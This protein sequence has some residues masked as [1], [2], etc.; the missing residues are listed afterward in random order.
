MVTKKESIKFPSLFLL[1]FSALVVGIL[2]SGYSYYIDSEKKI[3]AEEKHSLSLI[4]QFRANELVE[5]RNERFSDALIIYK[6][7]SMFDLIQKSFRNQMDSVLYHQTY[8]WLEIMHK[9]NFYDRITIIDKNDRQLLTVPENTTGSTSF[10]KNEIPGAMV[11]DSITWI[12]FYRNTFDKKIYI[13]LCI[14]IKESSR[15]NNPIGFVVMRIDPEKYL[16]AL[17]KNAVDLEPN[18]K[19]L[20]LR[21][22]GDSIVYLHD[23][24]HKKNAALN[25]R[26]SMQQTNVLGV[27]AVR[28]KEGIAEGVDYTGASVLGYIQ[29]IPN[30]PWY[31]VAK[32]D[33][34]IIDQK[35]NEQIWIVVVFCTALTFALGGVIGLVWRQQ[36]ITY[37]KEK[38]KSISELEFLQTVIRESLNEIYIFKERTLQFTFVNE[39]ASKNLGYGIGE[40]MQMKAFAIKP[41]FDEVKY[42]SMI[43]PLVNGEKE[44]IV[45]ETVHRRSD[46][47]TYPVETHLQLIIIDQEKVILAVVNDITL[48]KQAEERLNET[49]EYLQ[50]IIQYSNVP[51]IV[52][53]ETMRIIEFN[54]AFEILAQMTKGEVLGQQLEILFPEASRTVSLV[55]IKR[56]MSGQRWKTVEIPI[57]Q[58]NGNVRTV[59][60]NSANMVKKDGSFHFTVAQG[61]DVTMQLEGEEKIK[62]T[63]S[64]LER[65]NKEL[66]QFAY[67]ASHDLQ[68]PLRMVAS[69]TQ[70]LERR[71]KDRLDSDAN[72]FI[73]F[74]VDGANRMQRL[75][76][77]LL[78]FSRISTRGKD[79]T[80]VD[81]TSLLGVVNVNLFQKI[82]EN[83]AIITNNNLPMITCDPSQLTRLFQNLID[84]AI[85]YRKKDVI[86]IIHVSSLDHPDYVEFI[87]LDNGIGIDQQYHDRVFIIFQRLH[88]KDEYTGSGIG[89]A[90][91]KRIVER[92]GG[93]I[94]FDGAPGG[95]TAFH[96]TISKHLQKN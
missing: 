46:G 45:F 92:H 21:R 49:N 65:S 63:L 83:S 64:E 77:D 56:A 1:L 18:V 54:S 67:V 7:S 73:H 33:R 82:E 16:Y 37:L 26:I 72:E 22:D 35:L 23:I 95:G 15:G 71:Y 14:P 38:V 50:N 80:D 11:G 85:K 43:Q 10:N 88:S 27:Q 29:H 39:G 78:D 25:F 70:L 24:E 55:M 36:H 62:K 30:S 41:E 84:N 48:R 42:R 5:W 3:I 87:V 32:I 2:F 68:E 74:A 75:I 93:K 81:T 96:F 66:E 8:R 44:V 13:S 79:F 47:T 40:L 34:D 58:R 4:G 20:V 91:C 28:G 57:K 94:W 31:Y 59:L 53:D 52:W 6:N 9:Q 61:I 90:I 19:T 12:D 76:N 17:I 60:W 86:P 89:L 51:I 69:Y